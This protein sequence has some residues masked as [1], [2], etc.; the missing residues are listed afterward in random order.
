M[1]SPVKTH[2]ALQCNVNLYST[3]TCKHL[4]CS[5]SSNHTVRISSTWYSIY[6]QC[7]QR[8]SSKKYNYNNSL[9]RQNWN[10]TKQSK[11]SNKL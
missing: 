5:N 3:S 9:N 7:A 6:C 1:N 4:L 11:C 8:N 10:L 2:N